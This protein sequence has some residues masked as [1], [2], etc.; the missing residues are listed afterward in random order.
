[1]ALDGGL[2]PY[3]D[4]IGDISGS[5]EPELRRFSVW[6]LATLGKAFICS[7]YVGTLHHWSQ[8]DRG[9]PGSCRHRKSSRPCSAELSHAEYRP[10]MDMISPCFG[11][12]L[13]GWVAGMGGLFRI[14]SVNGRQRQD[15]LV[16]RHRP[17][18][19]YWARLIILAPAGDAPQYPPG[20]NGLR[21]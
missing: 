9:V 8:Q 1:M 6:M 7:F 21:T 12:I 18:I 10:V 4:R 16:T 11:R 19:L 3:Q 20:E 13:G 2:R 15:I 17:V 14:K 5:S